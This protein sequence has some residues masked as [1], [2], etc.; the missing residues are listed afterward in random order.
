MTNC[1]GGQKSV[2]HSQALVAWLL[3]VVL[4][5][6]LIRTAWLCDDAYITLRTVDN[7]V[8]GHGLT[9]NVNERVQA[10]THPLWMF[11]LAF[12][13]FFTREAFF[14]LH[15]V[16]IGV[17]CLA[18]LGAAKTARSPWTLLLGG[19]LLLLSKAFVD[20]STSGLENPL[21]HLSS[22]CSCGSTS[23]RRPLTRKL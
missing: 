23:A 14:T 7:F 20:Y 17:S 19:S 2:S 4:V 3:L 10:Y 1:A 21:T 22:R 9:W 15:I 8:H 5:A 11:V 6:L 13:Y 16:S 18:L 12:F